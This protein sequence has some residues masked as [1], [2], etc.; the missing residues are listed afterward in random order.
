MQAHRGPWA[1]RQGV[2][3]NPTVRCG[4]GGG[5]REHS[6]AAGAACSVCPTL[7]PARHCVPCGRGTGCSPAQPGV[8]CTPHFRMH[9]CFTYNKA[10]STHLKNVFAGTEDSTS[11]KPAWPAEQ[12]VERYLRRGGHCGHSRSCSGTAGAVGWGSVHAAT[13]QL[14]STAT[15]TAACKACAH[16]AGQ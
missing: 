3:R 7:A 14:A 15:G 10:C 9:R 4:E 5:R 11:W 12:P 13:T 16:P 8:W 6:S 1:A 2:H